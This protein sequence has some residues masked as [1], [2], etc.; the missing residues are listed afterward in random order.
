MNVEGTRPYLPESAARRSR[1]FQRASELFALWGYQNVELPT[2]EPY[3]PNHPLAERAF[4]LVDAGGQ[5][6]ALRS[7]Y[8]TALA[9]LLMREP[10]PRFP[11]RY[12][13]AGNL[14]LR[15]GSGEPLRLREFAQVGVELIG[16]S[17]PSADAEL[18]ELAFELCQKLG[19]AKPQIEIGLPSLVRDILSATGLEAE[20]VESLRRAIDRK[21]TPELAETL[22]GLAIEPGQAEI[23]MA[24][25]DLYGSPAVLADLPQT[26]LSSRA[27]SDLEWL[28]QVLAALP[29]NI[30]PLIDLGMA[31]RYTYYTGI[32]FRAYTPELGL[33]LL[34]GGRYDQGPE[35]SGGLLPQAAGFALGVERVM[36]ALSEVPEAGPKR[37]ACADLE[38]AR[39]LRARGYAVELVAGPEELADYARARGISLIGSGGK[40]SE[41]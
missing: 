19:I 20:I 14:F 16:V 40:V 35:G 34:G 25:P 24:L 17:S 23:I 32:T 12:Q 22:A 31:R 21:N 6:L 37:V 28:R 41:L 8:T 36:E 30:E 39:V 2:L 3:D 13:Y 5:V 15:Q 38:L 18:I 29:S 4:K 7:E 9:R 11:A 1:I 10:P 27:R 33:P 26:Q